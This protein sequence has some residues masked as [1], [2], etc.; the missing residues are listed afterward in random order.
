MSF[1]G[2]SLTKADIERRRAIHDGGCMA[3][4]QRSID[5]AG[6]GYVQW[7]HTAGKKRHDLTCGLCQWHHMGRTMYGYTKDQCRD[8]FGPSLFHE[9][10]AF[11][12]EFGSDAQLLEQQ[13]RILIEQGIEVEGV[14]CAEPLN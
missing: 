9:S 7:H 1:G 6:S 13:N 10:K 4:M 3:C 11:H 2:K 8:Y 5:M 12:A 14:E